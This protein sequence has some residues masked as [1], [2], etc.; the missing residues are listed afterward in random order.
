MD[1]NTEQDT[2]E[3][4]RALSP[5]LCVH[6]SPSTSAKLATPQTPYLRDLH[7]GLVTRQD[8]SNQ[9]PLVGNS[10]PV[11]LSSPEVWCGADVLTLSHMVS[12]G[13]QSPS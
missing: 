12:P 11:P 3:G 4:Y 10:T 1:K 6:L 5:T 7:G 8:W 9:W 13:A 2:G